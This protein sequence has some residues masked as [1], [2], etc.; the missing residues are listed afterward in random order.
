[1]ALQ[2]AEIVF[3][4]F[5]NTRALKLTEQRKLVLNVFLN[6]RLHLTIEEVYNKSKKRNPNIGLTT[7]WRTIKLLRECGLVSG[8]KHTDGIFRYEL[9]HEY[10][11]HLI[12]VKCGRVI[13]VMNPNPEVL[14]NKILPINNFKVLHWRLEL[15]GICHKCS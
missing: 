9:G 14:R 4:D 15:Y 7:V 1:M 13:E 5:L 6:S 8:F 3:Q 2:Q 11:E 12:C 10:H